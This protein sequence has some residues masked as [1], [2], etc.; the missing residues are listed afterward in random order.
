MARK[1]Q[2]NSRIKSITED[3]D[4]LKIVGYASTAD[5][6]RVGDV[7]VPDAW[8]KGGLTNY[9]KNPIILFNHDY[10]KPVG[11][12]TSLDVDSTGL[13]IECE[14][15]KSAGP[16]YG[17]IKDEV[18]S[19]FSVGFMI[20]DADY[21]QTS[22]GYII[23]DAEL[24]EV[25][26]V[27]VPCNQAATFSVSKSLGSAE[28][29]EAFNQEF[30]I[31]VHGQKD[32][33]Q[34]VKISDVDNSPK[35]GTDVP[36]EKIQMTPEETAALV[37]KS[38][39]DAIANQKALAD[40]AAKKEAEEK[41][42]SDALA[43]S[44]KAAAEVASKTT[45]EKLL[46]E[47]ESLL[48]ANNENFEK[49]FNEM[50]GS[51]EEKSN[52]LKAMT[53]SK[54]M[55]ADRTS[56]PF[57]SKGLLQEADDAFMLA[58][59][60]RKPI[61]QT[62]FGQKTIEK[63]NT[64]STVSVGTDRLETTVSTNIERD[65]WNELI[66]A[67]MFREIQ[68]NSAQMTFPLMPDAGYAEITSATTAAGSQPNGNM[69]QRGAGYGAPYQGITLTEK[70]LTTVKMIAKSYLGNETEEDAIIPIL[71]LIRESMVRSH[72]RG[73]ENMF[74][75]GNTNQGVYT[76]G[77]ANGL[78]KF[79]S[80]SGRT[81]TTAGTSTALTSAAL[82]G[83]RKLMGKYGLN[84]RDIVYV[85]S[86]DAYFQLIEDPEFADADLVGSQANKL[87]GEVGRL[88]GSQVVMCDEFAP[89]GP[90]N[91]FAMALNRRNFVVP[92]LR[93]MTVE[94]DYQTELQR[95]VLVTSQRL[96]FDEIIPGAASVI[97]LKYAS[98]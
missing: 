36:P 66:L 30:N 37:A 16:L 57:E 86:Q 28:K 61:D 70:T 22:D 69:D 4:Q 62:K 21:N 82:F 15:S 10:S 17:L 38:V 92:R 3:G 41:A 7:I 44:V 13:R 93:G 71:P 43:A 9:Q 79:A 14:I 29:L 58:K 80:T 78:L 34:E 26:V 24:L 60:L 56:D 42:A 23:R 98:A 96:G 8:T 59:V 5:T 32:D 46:G 47:F 45:E 65:I 31:E 68:M 83:M 11:R 50:K 52:E 27:S 12:A 48:K 81:L 63:F 75:A 55:F 1:F 94:S 64:H 54:R 33:E 91:Y 35:S 40:A 77:A 39:A 2:L 18:L 49:T 72:A 19:T 20:K 90:G 89:A 6:D 95:T 87:T 88:Y 25:S 73:V 74:L 53:E 67:P 97:G 76:S 85:V 84:P 51:L